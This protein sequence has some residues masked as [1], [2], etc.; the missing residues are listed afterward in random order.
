MDFA[1]LER[2][3][4]TD[5]DVARTYDET[6]AG[7]V[8][9][10]LGPLLVAAGVGRG[11]RVLDIA[12][13]PG[14]VT[15]RLLAAPAN[16]VSFDLSRAMLE[17]AR[18]RVGASL[19]PCRGSALELPFRDGSFDAT[20]CNL[21]LL[22]FPDPGAA[23]REGARVVRPGGKCAWSVWGPDAQLLRLIPESMEAIGARP[24]MPEA[25]GFFRFAEPGVFET[26]LQRAGLTPNPPVTVRFTV[27]VKSG[28]EVWRMFRDGTART[29]AGIAALSDEDQVRLRAEVTR[30]LETWRTDDGFL[31]PTSVV[32]GSG[33]RP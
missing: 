28:D 3:A 18:A 30:R 22:H 13:G 6:F 29:R 11:S 14:P 31:V 24:N 12:C 21:G 2:Q 20:V 5:P 9:P 8:G 26:D 17:R 10:S 23:L 16:A 19:T 27:P 33:R 32:I 15:Q 7:V 25:P 4:W 1:T